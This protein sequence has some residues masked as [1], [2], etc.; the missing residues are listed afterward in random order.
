[1]HRGGRG[2]SLVGPL[3]RVDGRGVGSVEG[4]E[5]SESDRVGERRKRS[6]SW[7]G[8][9]VVIRAGGPGDDVLLLD[10]GLSRLPLGVEAL[11]EGEAHRGNARAG[12]T[13]SRHRRKA[14]ALHAGGVAEAERWK[15]G[16]VVVRD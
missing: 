4:A 7:P 11:I 15:V 8:P 6:H 9:E 14:R 3:V 5:R 2:V 13:D 12:D 1:P 16:L 10:E